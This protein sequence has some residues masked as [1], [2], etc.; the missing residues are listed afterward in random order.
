MSSSLCSLPLCLPF[1]LGLIPV[2][3]FSFGVFF[4]KQWWKIPWNVQRSQTWTWKGFLKMPTFTQFLWKKMIVRVMQ[5]QKKKI[6][7][8]SSSQQSDNLEGIHLWPA[9][10][11][12]RY[13]PCC[14]KL[15]RSIDRTGFIMWLGTL[16]SLIN[17]NVCGYKRRWLSG[18]LY[19]T[20]GK[21]SSV[22]SKT[23]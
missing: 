12:V 5:P 8:L 13:H 18:Q 15:L 22:S 3:C 11:V 10:I 14:L 9:N 17:I 23:K 21:F 20:V 1:V 16:P 7:N 6:K 4:R 2:L 19:T